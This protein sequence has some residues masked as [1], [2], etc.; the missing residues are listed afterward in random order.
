VF[1]SGSRTLPEDGAG[2]AQNPI[3]TRISIKRQV[4]RNWG[5]RCAITGQRDGLDMVAI[6]PREAGGQL[7]VRNYLPM[8]PTAAHAWEHGVI[9]VG[10][11][12]NIVVVENQ[13]GADLLERMDRSGRLL[14]PSDPDLHPDPSDLAFH[15][16]NVLDR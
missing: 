2:E 3:E 4:L 8:I 10:P 9:S 6:R 12:G 14:L 1:A 15:L 5:E 13:L 11:S 16:Y 7:H